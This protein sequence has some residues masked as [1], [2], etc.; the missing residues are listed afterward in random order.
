M[1]IRS[2][3]S[4]RNT[5]NLAS[6]STLNQNPF[7]EM[8]SSRLTRFDIA[9]LNG[10]VTQISKCQTIPCF[11]NMNPKACDIRNYYAPL[12]DSLLAKMVIRPPSIT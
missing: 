12:R 6:A 2:D 8:A 9:F 3:G 7:F 10:A 5:G 11:Q 4:S 1:S